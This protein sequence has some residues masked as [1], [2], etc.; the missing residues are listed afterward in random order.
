MA[1]QPIETLLKQ[2]P[3]ISEIVLL[4]D[5]SGGVSALVLPSYDKLQ[6]WAREQ[7][8]EKMSPAELAADPAARKFIKAEIDKRSGDL[9]DFERIKRVALLEK[10]LSIE[11]GELTPTM[12]VKRKVV[13]ENYERLLERE[14][15]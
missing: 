7:G 6:S 5:L 3:Y 9:A 15:S 10:P 13:S 8:K 2:S 14:T 11:N 1:P 4:G 12:K